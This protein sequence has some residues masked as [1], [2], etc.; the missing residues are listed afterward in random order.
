MG[1]SIIPANV[2]GHSN[3]EYDNNEM[4]GET[5]VVNAE[6]D[7]Y[8]PQTVETP[9]KSRGDYAFI[10]DDEKRAWSWVVPHEQYENDMGEKL[11]RARV[12]VVEPVDIGVPIP[13]LGGHDEYVTS[14][15]KIVDTHWIPTVNPDMGHGPNAS[16]QGTLPPINWN[17]HGAPNHEVNHDEPWH[18]AI[19]VTRQRS[20]A[21]LGIT[22]GFG[23]PDEAEGQM[24]LGGMPDYPSMSERMTMAQA[25][26]RRREA[27]YGNVMRKGSTDI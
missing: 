4:F 6:P 14:R 20:Q 16:V 5:E 9:T 25:E 1:K 12:H 15:A 13:R 26:I 2:I 3:F 23:Q 21:A 8:L 7:I 18:R 10:S 24:V 19:E 11:G 22:K 17:Q 27:T